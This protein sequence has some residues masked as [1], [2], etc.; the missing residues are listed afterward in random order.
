MN[1]YAP[2]ND[3]HDGPTAF[4]LDVVGNWARRVVHDTPAAAAMGMALLAAILAFPAGAKA[5]SMNSETLGAWNEYLREVDANLQCRVRPGGSFLWTLENA[6]RAASVRRG[7]IIV[8]PAPG[9]NP[10]KVPGGL[11]HHWVGA[12]FLPNAKLD[13]IVEVTRDY[14]HYQDYYRPSVA[15]SKAI[16]RNGS[17]DEFSM[18]LLNKTLF[19][20]T[21]LEAT[22]ISNHVRVDDCRV[23]SVSKS[24]RVQGIEGYGQ[25][26]QH[27][28]PEGEG[29]SYLWKLYSIARLQQEKDGVYYEFEAIALSRDIPMGI[30]FLA[31][32]IVRRVS[33]DS[34]LISLQKT[35]DAVRRSV[36]TSTKPAGS[37]AT[38][39]VP[40]S[41]ANKQFG[42]TGVH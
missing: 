20:K 34:L 18:V 42:F 8:V 11:I 2:Q 12:M 39:S 21:A 5:A 4:G 40:A 24:T 23:Y 1:Y 13:E 22:Y 30:R 29:G 35:G 33:R 38:S 27:L 3:I 10:K 15:A 41:P 16:S 17:E 31:E 7:E 14:D 6:E 36:E 32:P 28:M 25:R 19:S 9:T 37:R 26:G